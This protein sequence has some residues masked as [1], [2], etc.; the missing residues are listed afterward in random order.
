MEFTD[1]CSKRGCDVKL[2]ICHMVFKSGEGGGG[3]GEEE[4]EGGG[5]KRGEA[6]GGECKRGQVVLDV[7]ANLFPTSHQIV[8]P[9]QKIKIKNVARLL[10]DV[11]PS[12]SFNTHLCD[13]KAPKHEVDKRKPK[14]KPLDVLG[15]WSSTL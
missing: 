9:M 12:L 14:R 7:N 11:S 3:G 2:D 4:E 1:P 10:P 13:C 6:Q 5:K 15:K 8:W